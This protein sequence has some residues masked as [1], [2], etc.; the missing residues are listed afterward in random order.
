M[1]LAPPAL[2]M[3][4]AEPDYEVVR[5]LG[6]VELRQYAPYVVAEAESAG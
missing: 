1:F 2:S 5:R 3:A 4:V 6:A